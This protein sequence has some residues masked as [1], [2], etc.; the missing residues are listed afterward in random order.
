[1]RRGRR[2]ARRPDPSLASPV[3]WD[4]TPT[5]RLGRQL[6]HSVAPAVFAI[7]ERGC[8]KRPQL[9]A[10]IR[11]QAELRLVDGYPTVRMTFA[12]A[13]I[14]IEDAPPGDTSEDPPGEAVTLDEFDAATDDADEAG[15]IEFDPMLDTGVRMARFRPDIVVEGALTEIIAIMTTPNVGGLP[16]LTRIQGWSALATLAAGRVRFRGNL[17]RA[18]ELVALLH[19]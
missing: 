15:T 8:M 2:R 12:D 7:V 4:V 19:I 6:P 14:F 9:A 10:Q 5:V 1:M 18:R 13:G 16:K 11:C 3:S 17:F